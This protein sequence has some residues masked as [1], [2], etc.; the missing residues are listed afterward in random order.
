MLRLRFFNV[1]I[2]FFKDV[3]P[4]GWSPKGTFPS[5]DR[6][7]FA[8]FC[9]PGCFCGATCCPG[10]PQSLM[11]RMIGCKGE[12]TLEFSGIRWIC[13]ER[14]RSFLRW[15]THNIIFGSFPLQTLGVQGSNFDM[16]SFFFQPNGWGF[17]NPRVW[18]MNLFGGSKRIAVFQV[19]EP[20]NGD[21]TKA[22]TL[23]FLEPK[24][25]W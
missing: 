24:I 20:R 4:E 14:L 13:Y 9:D 17:Q 22:S 7:D 25:Q 23:L 8:M 21:M 6:W 2:Y 16:F 11:T 15:K 18:T 3:K 10:T 19:L 1:S 12:M 5:F